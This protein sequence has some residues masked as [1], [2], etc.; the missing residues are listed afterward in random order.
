[1]NPITERHVQAIWYD[2]A[3]RPAR[4]CTRRG[5][6][7]TVVSPGEWNLGAGPDFRNA[8]LE[9]GKERRR[10]VGDVEI[11]LCPNDWDLHGHGADPR[12]R[13]VVAHVTWGCGP[14]PSSLP[15][16]AVSI[17]LGR[18]VTSDPAFSAEQID[19]MAYPYARLPE[20]IRPCEEALGHDPDRALALLRTAGEHRLRMKARRLAGRLCAA[21]ARALSV[22]YGLGM[23]T[24][25]AYLAGDKK[26]LAALCDDYLAAAD[27][28]EK[29]YLALEGQ[30]TLENKPQGFEVQD[31]RFGAIL[32][33]LAKGEATKSELE[34]SAG[35]VVK[36]VEHHLRLLSR[37]KLIEGRIGADGIGIYRLLPQN[38]PVF[39]E[40]LRQALAGK[41]SYLNVATGSERNLRLLHGKAAGQGFVKKIDLPIYD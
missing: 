21:A 30:W 32:R 15:P 10:V 9:L 26:A 13:N 5:S 11:H 28:L 35:V 29:L 16:G 38:H 34:A 19:L 22:K 14:V 27:A 12:Y 1:M 17:W 2:A 23:R 20:G 39:R 33:R 6:D 7:V 3:L 41:Q 8:V 25:E 4:L 24:R 40:L 37:A 31:A 18:F 36:T